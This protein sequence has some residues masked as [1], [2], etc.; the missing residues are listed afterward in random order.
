MNY[1]IN[2]QTGK[3]VDAYQ[4]THCLDF[5]CPLC[6][7][8]VHYRGR[9]N[10]RKSPHFAHNKGKGTLACENYHPSHPSTS[11]QSTFHQNDYSFHLDIVL[12][13]ATIKAPAWHL[14]IAQKSTKTG[15]FTIKQGLMGEVHTSLA[16]RFVPVAISENYQVEIT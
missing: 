3:V 6:R 12:S 1:A 13:K 15:Y 16:T 5:I 8:S 7:K 4:V 2:T 14:A 10:G 9:K 11:H